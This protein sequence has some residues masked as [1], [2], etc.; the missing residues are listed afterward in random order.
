MSPHPNV[1]KF[2]FDSSFFGAKR[3]SYGGGF[4]RDDNDFL[5]GSCITIHHQVAYSFAVKA[6]AVCLWITICT[7]SRT[8]FDHFGRGCLLNHS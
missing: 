4:I 5:M 2:N 7:P 8:S 6:I 3:K 1:V